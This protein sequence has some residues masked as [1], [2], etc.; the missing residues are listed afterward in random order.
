[1]TSRLL[2]TLRVRVTFDEDPHS[3]SCLD[4]LRHVS[5]TGEC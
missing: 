5:P 3:R 2:V 1:M 4:G